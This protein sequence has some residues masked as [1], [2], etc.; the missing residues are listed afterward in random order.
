MPTSERGEKHFS[1]PDGSPAFQTVNPEASVTHLFTTKLCLLGFVKSFR[2]RIQ[3]IRDFSL[4]NKLFYFTIFTS[5][6]TSF[7]SGCTETFTPKYY[8]HRIQLLPCPRL[9]HPVSG[10]AFLLLHR[11]PSRV[12]RLERT[13]TPTET[14]PVTSG[15]RIRNPWPHH[16]G[17]ASIHST[18]K[19]FF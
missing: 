4:L 5:F 8:T 15:F 19:L 6:K 10:A 1:A 11:K 3:I 17:V 16:N 18:Q 9:R 14:E 7:S 13:K 12:W 2:L